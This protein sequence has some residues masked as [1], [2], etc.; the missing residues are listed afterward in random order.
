MGRVRGWVHGFFWGGSS[1][2]TPHSGTPFGRCIR[3]GSHSSAAA[4]LSFC[5]GYEMLRY[6]AAKW[7]RGLTKYSSRISNCLRFFCRP[8]SCSLFNYNEYHMNESPE[9]DKLKRGG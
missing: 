4:E 6:I 8:S 1:G 7:F 9:V 2:G 5:S 3:L